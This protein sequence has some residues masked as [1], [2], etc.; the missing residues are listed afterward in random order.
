VVEGH[1]AS[2]KK[3]GYGKAV[4]VLRGSRALFEQ[5]GDHAYDALLAELRTRHRAKRNLMAMLD[6]LLAE[7][8]RSG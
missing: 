4:E 8:N 1:I 6:A 2:K 7:N 5:I 3:R